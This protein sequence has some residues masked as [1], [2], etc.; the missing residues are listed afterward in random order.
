MMHNELRGLSWYRESDSDEASRII[1]IDERCIDAPYLAVRVH[2]CTTRVSTIDR[3]V[4][5]N[6]IVEWRMLGIPVARQLFE[7]V[8]HWRLSSG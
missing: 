2:Q 5:L 6:V 4:G 8:A 3:C 7:T 1:G